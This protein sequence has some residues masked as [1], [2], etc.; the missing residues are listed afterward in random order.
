MNHLCVAHRRLEGIVELPRPL[1]ADE[2]VL[3]Q[4]FSFRLADGEVEIWFPALPPDAPTADWYHLENP[5]PDADRLSQIV[6]DGWGRA[7]FQKPADRPRIRLAST[8]TTVAFRAV[9]D[10]EESRKPWDY[11]HDFGHQ[12]DARWDLVEQWIELWAPGALLR[13]AA[14]AGLRSTGHLWDSST[15]PEQLTG[16]SPGLSV[17]VVV[18][19]RAL[20]SA[21]L[22][23][24]MQKASI[25]QAP[26]T[27][28]L[29]LLR[30]YEATDR[31]TAVIE[32]ATAAEIA[33]GRS[34][35]DRLGGIAEEAREMIVVQANGLIGM[36]RVIEHI[37]GLPQSSWR[38]VADRLA[39]P[40]NRAVHAGVVPSDAAS[41]LAEARSLVE[42]FS[43]LPLPE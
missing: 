5:L 4:R 12:F 25:G 42:R 2:D 43:P 40:R 10:P 24:A 1:F 6:G 14:P 9:V 27:E 18:S 19:R 35:H 31:R 36:L 28:W 17:S 38:R 22:T 39:N 37:D 11:A 26:P 21:T 32:A 41:A 15:D 16:W 7:N 3:G 23:G 20:D 8:A 30:A 33:L 34:L 13:P 29:F